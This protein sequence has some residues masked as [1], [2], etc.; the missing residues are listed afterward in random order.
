MLRRRWIRVLVLLAG[1]IIPQALLFGPSLFGNRILLPTDLLLF[2]HC[3][4][5]GATVPPEDP[6]QADLV[7][8]L[9]PFRRFAVEEIR[10][11]RIPLWNPWSYCGAPFLAN[12]QS[13]VFSPFQLLDCLFPGPEVLAWDQLLRAI[14][15]GI[16]A[17][18]FFRKAMSVSPVPAMLGA[19]CFPLCGFLIFWIGWGTAGVGVWL[20][21]ILLGV[22]RCLR[23]SK[24]RHV[25]LLATCTALMLFSG[26]AAIATQCLFCAGIFAMFRFFRTS[27][28]TKGVIACFVGGLAG[29]L[30]SMPQ[31]LPTLEY[32]RESI[33]IAERDE[34]QVDTRPVGLKAIFPLLLPYI[35]GSNK[36]DSVYVGNDNRF[37]STAQG[38]VGLW[39][40]LGAAPFAWT[41]R[42]HQ[43]DATFFA[44]LS[45]IG[46]SQQLDIPGLRQLFELPILNHF[47]ANRMLLWTAISALACGVCGIDAMCRGE[48]KL[49]K[50]VGLFA[51]AIAMGLALWCA[52]RAMVLPA[53]IAQRLEES[54][55][56]GKNLHAWFLQMHIVAAGFAAITGILIFFMLSRRN[57]RPVILFASLLLMIDLIYHAWG[58]KVQGKIEEYYPRLAVLD[59]LNSQPPG[60]V[61]GIGCF[62]PEVLLTQ[63]LP[64]VLGNDGA[65]PRPIV[66]LLESVRA[67]GNGFLPQARLVGYQPTLANPVLDLLGTKYLI[68]RNPL[69]KPY[70][71][72]YRDDLFVVNLNP[73]ALPFAFVPSTLQVESDPDRRLSLIS[74]KGFD[75]RAKA[76][77][78]LQIESISE[79]ID[80]S[81]TLELREPSLAIIRVEMQ[82]PGMVVFSEQFLPGWTAQVDDRPVEVIPVDHALQGVK[83]PAGTHSVRFEY[84]PR[85]FTL[86]C[87]LAIGGILPILLWLPLNARLGRSRYASPVNRVSS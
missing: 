63:R 42:R 58:V 10:A 77:L 54:Q 20:P 29:C 17:Y 46:A 70:Q 7:L 47:R 83:V 5:S 67:S 21:W 28:K 87:Y 38:Y 6:N 50:R 64:N 49:S 85:S 33:R 66:R 36:T 60:R 69:G 3:F 37:E 81:A 40:M 53:A 84:R 72:I 27:H 65:E 43:K 32:M 1:V 74:S 2:P 78:N 44:I 51:G 18:L 14:V 68:S 57:R 12:N 9:E 26:H 86:G 23:K 34:G 80:G 52:W 62:P 59:F 25:L 45:L 22:D 39:M 16:G 73:N 75:P 4:S 56:G 11:G 15:A 79:T 41:M 30:L 71:T 55:S 24:P 82:T 31:S 48:L 76:I 61:I 8:Q 35:D 13:A 19:W